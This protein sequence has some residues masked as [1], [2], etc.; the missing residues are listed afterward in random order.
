M[1]SRPLPALPTETHA[2]ILSFCD[3]QTLG[4][5]CRV[6]LAFLELASPHL[7]GDITIRGYEQLKTLFY[8]VQDEVR[9]SVSPCA[10]IR[11]RND[12]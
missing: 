12:C 3:P 8:D 6:S 7:Y 5:A 11:R 1:P 4:R 2:H 9:G 10:H